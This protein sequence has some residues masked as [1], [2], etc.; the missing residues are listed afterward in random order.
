MLFKGISFFMPLCLPIP[1]SKF[2]NM[3]E[4][5]QKILLSHGGVPFNDVF[6]PLW[7]CTEDIILAF[8]SFGS[9]K[10]VAIATY[11]LKLCRS[12]P[13]FK[14][15]FSRKIQT[16]I[17]ESVFATLCD[18]IEDNGWTKEFTYSRKDNSSMHILHRNGN[19]FI[20]IGCD[21]PAKIK[22]IKDPSHIWAEELD[23]FTQNDFTTLYSRLRTQ[24]AKCQFIGSFN[25]E[26][27]LDSHWIR[28]LFFPETLNKADQLA[29]QEE[30]AEMG[31]VLTSVLKIKANYYDNY[32]INQDEYFA[33][34]K[35]AACGNQRL[36]NAI[37]FGEWGVSENKC[38]WLHTFDY[39]K[40]VSPVEFIPTFPIYISFDFNRDPC[41][42]TLWQFSPQKG[43]KD[44]FIHCI[45][46]IGGKMQL[47]E[48]CQKVK[49]KYPSSIFFVT[50]D[51]SGNKGDV[52]YESKHHTSYTLIKSALNLGRK[53]M[54]PNEF[55]L[56]HEN[57][58][59]LMNVMFS[60]YPNLRISP[61][62]VNL[63]TDCE[64]A[65]VDEGSGKPHQLRKD[66][67][68]FKMDYFD[69]MRYFFQ[70]CFHDFAKSV[71]FNLKN[72]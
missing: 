13:Y 34:L 49:D 8:G 59:R 58:R 12:L 52:G 1:A 36:L 11:L 38:A 4:G 44:S 48:L 30:I 15:L 39:E 50:G 16:K 61:Q 71:Y 3:K 7:D 5:S 60:I 17:R 41:T 23:Q 29:A 31:T 51:C 33:K 43:L 64:I 65:E 37:A 47:R 32:F 66:R 19:V 54:L 45:D 9:G 2:I 57:S 10:S 25:T 6:I 68:K 53:Q 21:D 24:R 72:T 56:L 67:E 28:H 70:K 62:C 22:S 63:I 27:V 26:A 42:C 46:E 69:S 18:V 55:N 35:V 20:P 14:C 40:H